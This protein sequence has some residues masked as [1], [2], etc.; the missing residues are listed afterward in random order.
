MSNGE[1]QKLHKVEVYI[2]EEVKRVCEK[3]D[4]KYFLA[5]G[6]MLGAVRHKGF[7]PWDDDVD[8]G[9][10]SED[11]EKFLQIAPKELGEQFF[12]ENQ[13]TNK[14]CGF[15]FSKVRL[16]GTEFVETKGNQNAR[17][18]EFFVDIFPFYNVT[19][20]ER[21]R[22]K[23]GMKLSVLCQVLYTKSGYRVWEGDGVRKAIKFMPI[24]II[25]LFMTKSWLLKKIEK[26]ANNSENVTGWV[27]PHTGLKKGYMRWIL[28]VDIFEEHT[29]TVFEGVEF[30][31]LKKYDEFL[32][33]VYGNNYMELPPEENR[34]THKPIKIEF[35]K[36]NSMFE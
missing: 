27:W 8:I 10:M 11:Y 18:N 7:I 5:F 17:H 28:P 9:M 25:A 34:I 22:K 29:N 32:T 2:L 14:E 30:R 26:L 19:E 4:I 1:L 35:G 31:T 24:R 23:D 15:V 13:K 6:T 3:H 36:Y 12:L 20:N 33:R 21:K 16:L